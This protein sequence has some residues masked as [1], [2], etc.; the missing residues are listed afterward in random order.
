[1]TH[2][3]VLRV[4]V[5]VDTHK[6]TH[7][8]RAKDHLGRRLGD[9]KIIPTTP[10]GYR[11]LVAWARSL[12]QVEAFGVEGTGSW[13][14]GLARYLAAQG[15]AVLEVNRP[16]RQTRRHNG[17]SDPA[18]ADAAA[19]AVLS[20]DAVGL[21]KS[22]DDKVEM[23]RV[24]RVAGKTAVKARTQA[25][26]ALKAVVVTAPA[27]LRESLRTL[28]ATALVQKCARLRPGPLTTPTAATKAALR[29]L[30]ARYQSLS[31][32]M[33]GLGASL[34]QLVDKAAPALVALFGVGTDSAGALLVAAGDNP[35]R[36]HSEAGFSMLCGSSP[37]QASSG[38]VS[39][40]RLNRG[41]DRQANAA[42]HR[43]V[44]VRL[45]WDQASKDY[46][47]RRTTQG[48]SK[49]EVIRCLKRYVAREIYQ[50]LITTASRTTVATDAVA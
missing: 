11:E 31:K 50:V 12:G 22:G 21:P 34:D 23:V 37:V 4:T 3:D 39:R 14:A 49:R 48:K 13:G 33:T 46:M 7:V 2:D 32:E 25:M 41:G 10:E 45:C 40:H 16:N 15:V 20:G 36:M 38:K 18:D 19:S 47:V 5:G 42:L 29:S 30:A 35:E 17:K 8:A 24:L 9:A 26:N 27:E 6:E 28:S 1:M 43:I 44:L